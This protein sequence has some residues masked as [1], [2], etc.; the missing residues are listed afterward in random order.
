MIGIGMHVCFRSHV[1]KPPYA[2]FYDSYM[3]HK[4]EVV[5]IHEG[6]HLQL[7]CISGN[8]VVNGNVHHSDLKRL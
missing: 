2:P 1:F 8:I 3:G 7:K 4:F 6:H 5:A